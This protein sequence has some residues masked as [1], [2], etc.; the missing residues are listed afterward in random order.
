[1]ARN[2]RFRF[3]GGLTGMARKTVA[4]LVEHMSQLYEQGADAIRIVS[5]SA[6]TL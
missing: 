1:M 5:G 3:D 2:R 4:G 6:T